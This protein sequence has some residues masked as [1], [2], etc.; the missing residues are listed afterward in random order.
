MGSQ[1]PRFNK[2]CK[3]ASALQRCGVCGLCGHRNVGASSTCEH[4]EPQCNQ[5][6]GPRG[7]HEVSEPSMGQPNRA[8][9]SKA[10]ECIQS[11]REAVAARETQFETD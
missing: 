6:H 5:T 7:S 3:G 1:I 9:S 4:G 8:C 11:R 10:R 2:R